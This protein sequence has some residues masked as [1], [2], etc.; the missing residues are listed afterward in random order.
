MCL[1]ITVCLYN[2]LWPPGFRL[3]LF[4]IQLH[5]SLCGWLPVLYAL[6]GF[7]FAKR[8]AKKSQVLGN[9]SCSFPSFAAHRFIAHKT[10]LPADN[11]KFTLMI[12]CFFLKS[13]HLVLRRM[14]VFSMMNFTVFDANIKCAGRVNKNGRLMIV[15]EEAVRRAES[16]SRKNQSERWDLSPDSFKIYKRSNFI[17]SELN[18][19]P[20]V[21]RF[22]IISCVNRE[23]FTF[24]FFLTVKA[25]KT[26]RGKLERRR[27]N[28]FSRPGPIRFTVVFTCVFLSCP[29]RHARNKIWLVGFWDAIFFAACF[30]WLSAFNNTG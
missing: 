8:W 1:H 29:W 27:Q 16:R 15:S 12:V 23:D 18:K 20:S 30:G 22:Y 9:K 10:A 26:W 2:H 28:L 21:K 3:W 7:V 14:K 24:I 17:N 11:E 25:W 13:N 4:H 6:Y 5:I 19:F